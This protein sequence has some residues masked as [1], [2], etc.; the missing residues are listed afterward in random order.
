MTSKVNEDF[1]MGPD[2]FLNINIPG[3]LNAFIITKAMV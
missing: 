2:Q 3:W 1:W